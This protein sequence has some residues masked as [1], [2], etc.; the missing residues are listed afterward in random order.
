MKQFISTL[1]V[2]SIGIY[3][4]ALCVFSPKKAAKKA[5]AIFAT[6]RKGKILEHQK[7]F[8]NTAKKDTLQFD[9]LSIT[10]YQWL[11]KKDS[12]LLVHGWESNTQRWHK[13][14]KK[15]QE[16]DYHIIALDAPA[17]GQSSGKQ[18]N[19]IL[20]AKCIN[21]VVKAY[22]PQIIVGHSVGGMASVFF[23]KLFNYKLLKKLVLL[24]AP[25]EFVNIFKNYTNMLGLSSKLEHEIDLLVKARFGYLPN[26]FSTANF[27][28]DLDVEGLII[29]D[30]EDQIITY[31]EALLIKH[32]FKNAKLITTT[33]YGHSLQ[34]ESIL[35][36][37]T[38]FINS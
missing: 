17:H 26:Y 32:N 10:T 3:L 23:T 28:K 24:G 18:F 15:L 21:Q 35:N 34:H 11:G 31:P 12:I 36:H 6:P 16:Q 25:S 9:N 22:E 14:I 30:T 33:G 20:Y 37:V 38:E 29:H 27:A 1:I 13:L 5:L 19:A 7:P 4:N 2:K 8:L